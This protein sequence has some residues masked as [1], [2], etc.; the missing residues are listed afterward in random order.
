L[1][2]IGPSDA[3]RAAG[4]MGLATRLYRLSIP[5]RRCVLCVSIAVLLSL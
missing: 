4:P 2:S 5:V 1:K 3:P